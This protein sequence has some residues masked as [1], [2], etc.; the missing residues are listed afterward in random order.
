MLS[1]LVK[2]L[3]TDSIATRRRLP[4]REHVAFEDLMRGAAILTFGPYYRGSDFGSVSV[5][6]RNRI[7]TVIAPI[8]SPGLSWS[9]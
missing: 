5:S 9:T 7:V 3:C 4:G 8:W 6:V 2:V 1:M